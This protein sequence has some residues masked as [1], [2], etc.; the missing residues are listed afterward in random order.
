MITPGTLCYVARF[1]IHI[2]LPAPVDPD[3]PES[4][5]FHAINHVPDIER[6]LDWQTPAR[7]QVL[8][9]IHDPELARPQEFGTMKAAEKTRLDRNNLAPD[10]RGKHW[11]VT[12]H[13]KPGSAE[14]MQWL[15]RMIAS[16]YSA[17][18]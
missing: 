2:Y 12:T 1:V 9:L 11:I 18:L 17:R 14:R 4:V 10:E 6:E 3:L 16:P 5:T 15:A 7:D 8:Q 13:G